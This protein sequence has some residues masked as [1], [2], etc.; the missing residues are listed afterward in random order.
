MRTALD[1]LQFEADEI[2]EDSRTVD[3]LDVGDIDFDDD[4]FSAMQGK[5]RNFA[6]SSRDKENQ[7][8]YQRFSR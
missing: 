3:A 7:D 2:I 6:V 8:S 5:A 4:A 1:R